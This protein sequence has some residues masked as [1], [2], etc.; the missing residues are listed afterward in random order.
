MPANLCRGY[1]FSGSILFYLPISI[2][3]RETL[4]LHEVYVLYYPYFHCTVSIC[5]FLPPACNCHNLG[6]FDPFCRETDGQCNCA[7]NAYG[8]RCDEC[9]PGYWQGQN[10]L[11]VARERETYNGLNFNPPKYVSFYFLHYF[12]LVR[13]SVSS[14]DLISFFVYKRPRSLGNSVIQ[15]HIF[16]STSH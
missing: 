1:Y 7:E 15:T 6:S 2:L 10:K 4:P 16:H 11:R 8:R 14:N 9:Q 5:F 13:R 3:S 12:P